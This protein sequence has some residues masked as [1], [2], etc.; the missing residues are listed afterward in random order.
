MKSL[1]PS[2]DVVLSEMQDGTAVLLHLRTKFYFTLNATG[3]FCWNQLEQGVE[4]DR[5]P[6]LL[7]AR[8]QVDEA[9]ARRDVSALLQQ[10]TDEELLV[11]RS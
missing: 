3:L 1:A 10:L 6:S 5:L 2:T 7:A 11:S 4:G 8:F 9:T